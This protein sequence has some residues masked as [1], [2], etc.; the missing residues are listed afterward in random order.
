[1]YSQ[2]FV[3]IKIY[4]NPLILLYIKYGYNLDVWFDMSFFNLFAKHGLDISFLERLMSPQFPCYNRQPGSEPGEV[5][6]YDA[7]M[8]TK[9]LNNYRSHPA[10]IKVKPSPKHLF[11]LLFNLDC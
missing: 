9:L 11:S 7:K 10:I 1:M 2:Y 6:S 3:D 5:G 8:V 4:K